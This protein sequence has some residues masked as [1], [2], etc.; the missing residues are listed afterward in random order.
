MKLV[1]AFINCSL[2][3]NLVAIVKEV[4]IHRHSKSCRKY[5]TKCRFHFPRYPSDRTI[6]AQPLNK[7][8]FE[9]D[10]AYKEELGKHQK[11]LSAVKDVL[12]DLDKK[13]D[14]LDCTSVSEML[15]L[16]KVSSDDYYK[17]LEISEKGIV[18]LLKREV[19]E[20]YVYNYNTEW[21]RA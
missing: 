14:L 19:H 17:A 5:G 12:Y 16:A 4:Q 3:N 10:E 7:S 21:L 1:D 13:K 20:I 15:K 2:K 11:A 9:T 6:I 8:D 18:V